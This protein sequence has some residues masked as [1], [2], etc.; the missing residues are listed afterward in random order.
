MVSA[1]SPV[2]YFIHFLGLLLEGGG[3]EGEG[4]AWGGGGMGGAGGCSVV[5]DAA[6]TTSRDG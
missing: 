3:G 6:S 4:V 5:V 2:E 1:G